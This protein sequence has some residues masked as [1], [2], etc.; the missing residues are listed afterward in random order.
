MPSSRYT[1]VDSVIIAS[2]VSYKFIRTPE[3]LF[4]EGAE[5]YAVK[6][7]SRH[8]LNDDDDDDDDDDDEE[9]ED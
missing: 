2:V 3:G 6:Q 9:E 8:I 1:Y 5:N 4:C 7:S